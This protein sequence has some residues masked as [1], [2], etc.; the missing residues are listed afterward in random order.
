MNI[1]V[2]KVILG[3][4]AVLSGGW[5][6]A[7]APYDAVITFENDLPRVSLGI[8][9]NGQVCDLTPEGRAVVKLGWPNGF[10]QRDEISRGLVAGQAFEFVFRRPVSRAARSGIINADVIGVRARLVPQAGV[11]YRARVKHRGMGM[12]A[13]VE[14]R[15]L[16]SNAAFTP[17]EVEQ[18]HAFSDLCVRGA[19]A[20]R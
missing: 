9:D 15:T 6:T 18:S 14:A 20:R 19:Y 2:L 11:E 5:A 4:V 13:I 17:V 1:A 12:D 7:A 8:Y 16:G 10:L 3:V